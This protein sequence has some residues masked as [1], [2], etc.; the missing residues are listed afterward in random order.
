MTCFVP[1][2][3]K[4][5]H[6]LL[7]PSP[8]IANFFCLL[9]LLIPTCSAS[10]PLLSALLIYHVTKII[11]FTYM[12]TSTH[13]YIAGWCR[14]CTY[15]QAKSFFFLHVFNGHPFFFPL[16][17]PFWV[18]VPVYSWRAVFSLPCASFFFLCIDSLLSWLW[19]MRQLV[20]YI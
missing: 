19:V 12:H 14:A 9:L 20:T 15:P 3:V 8:I 16:V 18:C 5:P 13:V 7:L 4:K 11:E 1:N 6:L 10:S 17:K 2:T